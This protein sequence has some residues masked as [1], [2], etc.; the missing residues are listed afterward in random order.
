MKALPIRVGPSCIWGSSSSYEHAQVMNDLAKRVADRYAAD[1]FANLD[2]AIKA[3]Q[4]AKRTKNLGEI[5]SGLTFV[6]FVLR[7]ENP[8]AAQ[9]LNQAKKLLP[10]D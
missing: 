6:E 1:P 5:R 8:K 7:K 2:P 4:R 3:F 9:L 10:A